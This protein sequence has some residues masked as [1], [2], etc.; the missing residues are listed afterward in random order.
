MKT[1]DAVYFFQNSDYSEYGIVYSGSLINDFFLI[2]THECEKVYG[3]CEKN[4]FEIAI[5]AG[6]TYCINF[7]ILL[8]YMSSSNCQ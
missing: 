6:C 2:M 3:G 4:Y 5:R 1:Y 7:S 8:H